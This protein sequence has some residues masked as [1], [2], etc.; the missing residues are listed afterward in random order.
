MPQAQEPSPRPP[1][2]PRTSPL[3]P[4]VAPNGGLPVPPPPPPTDARA[5]SPALAIPR[6]PGS[7]TRSAHSPSV[8]HA[9]LKAKVAVTAPSVHRA[10]TAKWKRALHSVGAKLGLRAVSRSELLANDPRDTRTVYFGV[11]APVPPGTLGPYC[12][13]AIRT[14]KYSVWTF[15]PRNLAEQFSKVANLYFLMIIVLQTIPA[16]RSTQPELAAMPVLF[17]VTA[18]ALKDAFEDYKRH[19]ADRALN[20]APTRV[21][22]SDAWTNVNHP[23]RTAWYH[24][25]VIWAWLAGHRDP[26]AHVA[27]RKW[28]GPALDVNGF[29]KPL[30]PPSS[31][32]TLPSANPSLPRSVESPLPNVNSTEP[33]NARSERS[34]ITGVPPPSSSSRPSTP[35]AATAVPPRIPLNVLRRTSGCPRQP[36]FSMTPIPSATWKQ[37]PWAAVRV[38]DLVQ[39]R[40]N[41]PIPADL[42]LLATSEKNGAAYVETK[43]LDGETNLKLKLGMPEF[44][45]VTSP[46]QCEQLQFAIESEPPSANLYTYRGTL[47]VYPGSPGP[48]ARADLLEVPIVPDNVLLRGCVVRN[49]DWAIGAVLYTGDETKIVLNSGETPSKRSRIDREMNPQIV[50]NFMILFL[51][52]LTCAVL[53]TTWARQSPGVFGY[54][55][56]NAFRQFEHVNVVRDGVYTFFS[57]LVVFQNIVPIS[58]YI[59]IELVKTVQAFFIY[60]D[61]DLK[62][63]DKP[64]VPKTW[65]ISDN[66][67]QIEFIFSDKTG[68]LTQNVMEFRQCCIGDRIYG[69][70]GDASIPSFLSAQAASLP[71]PYVARK[72]TFGDPALIADLVRPPSATHAARMHHFW[73]LLATCHTVLCEQSA[74]GVLEYKA[75]SPDEAALVASARDAGFAFTGRDHATL[76]LAVHGRATQC[77]LLHLVEFTSARKRMSVLVRDAEGRVYVYCKGADSVIFD[78]LRPGQD[79]LVAQVQD[80]LEQFAADGLRT[81]CLAYRELSPAEYDALAVRFHAASILIDGR[82]AALEAVATDCEVG[83]ELLGATAI[84]DKLQVG[85][86]EAIATLSQANIHIWVL[87]GDKVETAINIGYACNLIASDMALITV[88]GANVAEQL[89]AALMLARGPEVVESTAGAVLVIDGE[90]LTEAV[91]PELRTLFLRVCLECMHVLI[92]RVSPLQKAQVVALVR[93]ELKV[94]TL[95]IGDGANDV[96]MIQEADVGVGI[97]G[98]EGLQAVLSSDYAIGQFRFLVKLL[99]VHG[100]WSN[101][102]VAGM[103]H[104]FFYKNM[105]WV[106]IMFWYQFFDGFSADLMYDY[107]LLMLYNLLFTQFPVMILGVFEQDVSA[108][109]ALAYPPL[110]YSNQ[111]QF[112]YPRFWWYVSD[113]VFQSLVIFFVPVIVSHETTS[114]HPGGYNPSKYETTIGMAMSAVATVNLFVGLNMNS[115]N[116]LAV[117]SIAFCAVSLALYLPIIATVPGAGLYMFA[118]MVYTE[119]ALPLVVFLCLVLCLLPRAAIKY[120]AANYRPSDSQIIREIHQYKLARPP[121][122]GGHHHG[123]H[124]HTSGSPTTAVISPTPAPPVAATAE[125]RPTS[126]AGDAEAALGTIFASKLSVTSISPDTTAPAPQPPPSA[127]NTSLSRT[128]RHVSWI[129]SQSSLHNHRPTS[130]VSG[131]SA[132]PAALERSNTVQSTAS[133][134]RRRSLVYDAETRTATVGRTGFAFS[135]AHGMAGAVEAV[136][137]PVLGA[138]LVD[139]LNRQR[140]SVVSLEWQPPPDEED[141]DV[142]GA[143]S[144]RHRRTVSAAAGAGRWAP[145]AGNV[146]VEGSES[147]WSPASTLDRPRSTSPDERAGSVP[148]RS[149]PWDPSAGARP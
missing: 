124:R 95:A 40:N 78:S 19:V 39:L 79:E 24:P 96:S 113:A 121:M 35:G 104:N 6:A 133:E 48:N 108:K 136:T 58:L 120:W 13:N 45:H 44:S 76:Q 119:P 138:S 64:C 75:Q 141:V 70:G 3:P 16:I 52:C 123:H 125:L 53:N 130:A 137:S 127:S 7:P 66:L 146:I 114:I 46:D 51:M 89:E 135:Q 126:K 18:T 9:A 69:A 81:L 31:A 49:T 25:A 61:E 41:D 72:P 122:A 116:A 71:N 99:L 103:I 112:T 106:F 37:V 62:Y 147:T 30:V 86:P 42:V 117:S 59:S 98:E 32:S 128:A 134:R 132:P 148:A 118:N 85:V 83:L 23:T 149:V 110:Y 68:T 67:G 88:R 8:R 57:C 20:T 105:T 65:N 142:G 17:I 115:L 101:V 82:E 47:R 29:P 102:R 73:T 21:L 43:S 87:T 36:S 38:G 93:Q 77:T 80:A 28:K 2:P 145:A 1:P 84:E 131:S 60:V 27:L 90:A 91:R 140:A 12:A 10:R 74:P 56:K 109:L 143:M 26:A 129:D 4:A 94:V 144:P 92:C 139:S 55:D 54:L 97:A 22:A 14:A 11:H 15:L 50:I 34:S 111:R 63:N 100:R 5:P 33:L 107:T